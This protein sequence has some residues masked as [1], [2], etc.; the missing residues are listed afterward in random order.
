MPRLTCSGRDQHRLAVDR[1]RTSCSSPGATAS[2]LTSAYPMRWVKLTLPP[3]P[4]ARWLLITMRLSTSS[5]AG[6]ARTLVAVGTQR[7]VHVLHDLARR[8]RAAGVRGRGRRRA[9]RGLARPG[10]RGGAAG[11][12]RAW[13]VRG[14]AA[15]GG[16]GAAA[17]RR[18]RRAAGAACAAVAE[19]AAAGAAAGRLRRPACSRRR[20]RARPRPRWPGR[21]GTAG[22]CRRRSTRWDRSPLVGCPAK[23]AESTQPLSS[24]HALLSR[25]WRGRSECRVKATR[26]S[27]LGRIGVARCQAS[28]AGSQM[29]RRSDLTNDSVRSTAEVAQCGRRVRQE[30]SRLRRITVPTTP[31]TTPYA[32]ITIT[33]THH[34][35]AGC[36]DRRR[37]GDDR[38]S[39][40]RT[41]GTSTI[42]LQTR[43]S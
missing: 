12:S 10:W 28:H 26:S 22:T 27:T 13:P 24:L 9:V 37:V 30:M 25:E 40:P 15:C 39:A 14:G 42:A 38:R 1:R 2:A 6:T 34:G 3:R 19:P 21:P 32:S 7:R 36:R 23:S 5:F 20:T 16:A 41:A 29:H 18:G 31:I 33:P 43:R 4:R 11:G 8:R 17:G 35:G